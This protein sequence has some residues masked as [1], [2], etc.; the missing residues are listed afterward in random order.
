MFS[1]SQIQLSE[2]GGKKTSCH[3][4]DH[5]YKPIESNWFDTSNHIF[6]VS[7]VWDSLLCHKEEQVGKAALTGRR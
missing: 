4:S 6:S 7:P 5:L 1:I 3:G 2:D